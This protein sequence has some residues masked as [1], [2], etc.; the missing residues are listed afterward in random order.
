MASRH[1]GRGWRGE[2]ALGRAIA[3]VWALGVVCG[4]VCVCG[5]GF[6]RRERRRRGKRRSR[7][8]AAG[9]CSQ[10]SAACAGRAPACQAA[11]S[12]R[13]IA[14][15][16]PTAPNL[17]QHTRTL[18]CRY[19]QICLYVITV[20]TLLRYYS[21]YV[22]TDHTAHDCSAATLV[23]F[24][25]PGRLAVRELTPSRTGARGHTERPHPQQSCLISLR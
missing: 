14:R 2:T 6:E 8:A 19:H 11:Y 16:A 5:R 23:L 9:E 24:G 15:L 10:A 13:S 4:R 18:G 12:A 17:Q 3:C 1:G 22:I 25:Y 20:I 21:Y 7:G